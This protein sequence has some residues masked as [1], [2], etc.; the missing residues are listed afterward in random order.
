MYIY[1]DILSP[2][3]YNPPSKIGDVVITLGS[4][5]LFANYI[6]LLCFFSA[7]RMTGFKAA[8]FLKGIWGLL[9]LGGIYNICN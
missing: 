1:L 9:V 5:Y 8:G 6:N 4:F 2:I 7:W 3:I